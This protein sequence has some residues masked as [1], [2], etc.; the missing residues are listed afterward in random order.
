MKVNS[1]LLFAIGISFCLH[2]SLLFLESA[3][4]S[5]AE[6]LDRPT[7]N[8][9]LIVA[10]AG[11]EAEAREIIET[12]P[13]DKASREADATATS[14]EESATRQVSAEPVILTPIRQ[15]TYFPLSELEEAP[16]ILHDI[17][18][19]PANLKPY[20]Q[21]GRV[22]IQLWIDEQGNVVDQEL[23][24]TML[25]SVFVDSAMHSFAQAKFIA[26]IKDGRPVKSTL[27]VVINYDPVAS[28]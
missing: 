9:L 26:G 2:V 13:L 17:D 21:G 12:N 3:K 25:P 6:A 11:E 23:V 27:K 5:R 16:Q 15:E 18:Q 4:P 20:S 7:S 14:G 24:E 10:L 19:D 8:P 28:S 22:I 1:V